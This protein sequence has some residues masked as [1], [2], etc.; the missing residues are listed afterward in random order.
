MKVPA[1]P[2]LLLKGSGIGMT[3]G[4]I[5]VSFSAWHNSDDAGTRFRTLT[6]PG[7]RVHAVCVE[8]RAADLASLFR[9]TSS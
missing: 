8:A 5:R 9:A 4:G 3:T 7:S 1:K 6:A 2:P